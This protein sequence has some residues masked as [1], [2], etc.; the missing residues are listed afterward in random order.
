[1]R[2]W[3]SLGPVLLLSAEVTGCGDTKAVAATVNGEKI[4]REEAEQARFLKDY[5]AEHGYDTESYIKEVAK[6]TIKY[7]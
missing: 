4:Y 5:I 3:L 7:K 2:I 6:A 1:M